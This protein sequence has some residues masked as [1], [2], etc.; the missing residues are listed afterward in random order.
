MDSQHG[1]AGYRSLVDR[2]IRPK[3]EPG[4]GD[5]A[6]PVQCGGVMR[7][8]P[9]ALVMPQ[10]QAPGQGFSGMGG[11]RRPGTDA[12]PAMKMQ[13]SSA[14]IR[15]TGVQ[16]HVEVT[17]SRQARASQLGQLQPRGIMSQAGGRRRWPAD[18]SL[19]SDADRARSPYTAGPP[20]QANL[21]TKVARQRA[22]QLACT[23]GALCSAAGVCVAAVGRLLGPWLTRFARC[24]CLIPWLTRFVH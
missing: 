2:Q 14:K 1:L 24:L 7:M 12:M 15:G 6:H 4:Q 5:A 11:R 20:A 23:A 22:T 8:P 9:C 3:V 13:F 17:T 10:P 18:A 21:Q 16:T 19:V